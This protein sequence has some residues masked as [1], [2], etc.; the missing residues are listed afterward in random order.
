M[1]FNICTAILLTAL[2]RSV[3]ANR[4]FLFISVLL[5]GLI[6]GSQIYYYTFFDTYYIVVS[7]LHAGMV[8]E[9]YSREIF[10]LVYHH[11]EILLLVNLPLLMMF[12][13][14]KQLKR[15]PCAKRKTAHAL[16]SAV[17]LYSVSVF[18]IMTMDKD[19]PVYDAYVYQSDMIESVRHLGLLTT[20][21]VDITRYVRESIG[22]TNAIRVPETVDEGELPV[23][24]TPNILPIPFESL[25]AKETNPILKSMH[26]YYSSRT[27][28][29]KNE[30][31]GLFKDYN[32][33]VITAETFSRWAVREDIT[34]TLYRLVHSGYVFTDFYVPLYPVSTSDGEY[35]G[36]TSQLPKAGTWSMKDSSVNDM[37]FVLGH[38]LSALGYTT[39]AFHNNDYKYYRRDLSHPNLGYTFMGVGNGLTAT[40]EWPQS[41]LDMM[42]ETI[43]MYINQ[44]K[45]HVYYMTVSGHSNYYW[46]ANAQAAKNR[47]L[48]KDLPYIE[49]AK[50]YLAAQ[51]EL[52]KAVTYLLDELQKA[53]RLDDTLIVLSADHYPYNFFQ[54]TLTNI[55]N[56][57][58][59]D[60]EFDVYRSP[61]IIYNPSIKTETITKPVCS[62]DL[63]PTIANLMGLPYDSRL[64]MGTDAFSPSDGLVIFKDRSFITSLGRY[65][66]RSKSFTP[67]S[68]ATLEPDYVDKMIDIVNAKFYYSQLFL[69]KDYYKIIDASLSE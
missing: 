66:V 62:L 20:I 36:L 38:Q 31:T 2:A 19:T 54:E 12:V 42:K 11:L 17:A 32:L 9:S 60:M 35:M 48:V 5:L 25:I 18:G 16:L 44:D 3:K 24:E 23:D 69:E 27:P 21:T 57:I 37:N 6:Y 49:Y 14:R 67:N 39:Y 10:D 61:L 68:G 43:P 55:N 7:L 26:A 47:D 63:L 50:G 13:F 28:S 15:T 65:D 1:I 29:A 52:E 4:A 40:N 41:D 45:F 33:I 53:G 56:G 30:K 46:D 22:L 58:E 34:P 51:I 8:A 64:M 59:V